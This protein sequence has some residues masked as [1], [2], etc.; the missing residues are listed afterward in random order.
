MI[1]GFP[2]ISIIY[3]TNDSPA[4]PNDPGRRAIQECAYEKRWSG[5][6]GQKVKT[7]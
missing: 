6:M 1:K 7:S 2:S 3:A 5:E 4:K